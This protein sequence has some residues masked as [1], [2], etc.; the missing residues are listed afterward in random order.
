MRIE[1]GARN[2]VA[3]LLEILLADPTDPDTF[4]RVLDKLTRMTI[5]GTLPAGSHKKYTA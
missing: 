5:L 2:K 1:E 3:E 4:K